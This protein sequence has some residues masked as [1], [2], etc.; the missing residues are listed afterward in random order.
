MQDYFTWQPLPLSNIFLITFFSLSLPLSLPSNGYSSLTQAAGIIKKL[1][2]KSGNYSD[3]KQDY[4]GT[5]VLDTLLDFY[6][7]HI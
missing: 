3:S 4:F 5:K 7:I 6:L 1:Q 2:K